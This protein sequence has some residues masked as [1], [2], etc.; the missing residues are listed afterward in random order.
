MNTTSPPLAMAAPRLGRPLAAPLFCVL[1]LGTLTLTAVAAAASDATRS[2]GQ[3]AGALWAARVSEDW[4]TVY[5]LLPDAKRAKSSRDEF[6][7]FRRE[8]G[9][10]QFLS[11]EVE[12]VYVSGDIGWVAVKFSARP[13]AYPQ[14][15][16][17]RVETWDTWQIRD[18]RWQALSQGERDQ[19]PRLPPARR[20]A[21]EERRLAS[22]ANA[23][24]Q[25]KRRQDWASIHEY[26][27]PDYQAK[28]P[29]EEFLERKAMF[30]YLDHRLEW[31]EVIGNEGR[32]KIAYTHKLN[33]PSVSKMEPKESANI[34]AWIKVGGQWHRRMEAN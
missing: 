12:E 25:A 20:S 14:L 9:P 29:L 31:T 5:D 19:L 1:L 32:V 22:R 2:L 3:A 16:P 17:T 8:K 34:E 7:S 28:V 10:F 27:E 15:P 26:L 24:W 33:D 11:A 21:A 6:V 30:A 18:G 4:E 23:F 13:R